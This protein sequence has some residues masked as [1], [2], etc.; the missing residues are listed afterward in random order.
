MESDTISAPAQAL[1]MT[2]EPEARFDRL[3]AL[4]QGD[5]RFQSSMLEIGTHPAYQ[6]IVGMG[7]PVLPLIFRQ[8][9][10]K[11]DHWFWALKA[12]TGEDPVADEDRGNLEAMTTT[13]LEWGRKHGYEC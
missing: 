7:P 13:W 12:I 6:Q 9:A 2:L 8:L 5:T 1:P 3:R 10:A 11:P 4:W